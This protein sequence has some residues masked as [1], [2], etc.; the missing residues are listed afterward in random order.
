MESRKSALWSAVVAIALVAPSVARADKSIED[1]KEPD[2]T[3][4]LSAWTPAQQWMPL[5]T[6]VSTHG[7]GSAAGMLVLADELG[8]K[9]SERP[10]CLTCPSAPRP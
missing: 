10:C 5:N 2:K 1:V 6:R 4:A 9:L 3:T 8:G 7:Y